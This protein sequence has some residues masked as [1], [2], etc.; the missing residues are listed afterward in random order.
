MSDP[1][2]DDS[3]PTAVD[4][5]RVV[6][7]KIA[8]EDGGDVRKHIDEANRIVEELWAKLNVRVNQNEPELAGR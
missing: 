2:T 7:E 3:E 6:R 1:K 8:R 5:V 4:D